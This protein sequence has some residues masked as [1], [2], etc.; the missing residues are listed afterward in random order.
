MGATLR[1]LLA[2]ILGAGAGAAL[3]GAGADVLPLA[4]SIAE[5]VGGLWLSALRMSIVP[6]VFALVITGVASASGTARSGGLAARAL[7]LM[8][9]LLVFSALLSA[10]LFP[11]LLQA[12]PIETAGSAALRALGPGSGEVPEAAPLAAWWQ[13]IVPVNPV[14]AAAEGAMLPLVVFALAFGF[15]AMRIE[16]TARERLLGFFQA[17]ADALLVIVQWV[18]AIAPVGVFALAFLLGSRTGLDAA[19][20]LL[21]YVTLLVLLMA[22]MGLLLYPGATIAA[23]IGPGRFARAVLPAQAVA[24]STQ[25][26]LASLPAMVTGCQQQLGVRPAVSALVLPLAVSV[27]RFSSPGVNLAVALYGAHLYGVDVGLFP[28]LGA[29]AVAVLGSMASVSLPGQLTFYTTA[30]PIWLVL[31]LPLD[32]LPLLLAVEAIPDIFRTVVNVT[33]DVAVTA[34]VDRRMGGGADG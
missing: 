23:Q 11:L 7:A 28:M 24:A 31:G 4:Q 19:G 21:H 22:A 12:F 20:A 1:I 34:V 33:A 16:S 29:M 32:L 6:L 13:G 5:P 27:F 30:T 25:S 2:L 26:S 10:T 15:A 14:Q 17:M 9:G 8:V 3:R 18:L